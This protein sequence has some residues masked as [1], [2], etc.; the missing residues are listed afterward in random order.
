M[1]RKSMSFSEDYI[2]ITL[3]LEMMYN[4]HMDEADYRLG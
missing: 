4:V 1:I 3:Q 2:L